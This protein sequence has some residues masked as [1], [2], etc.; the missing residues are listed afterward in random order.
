MSYRPRYKLVNEGGKKDEENKQRRRRGA[1]L[2]PCCFFFLLALLA[3]IAIVVV[4]LIA[5]YVVHPSTLVITPVTTTTTTTLAPTTTTTAILTTPPFQLSCGLTDYYGELEETSVASNVTITGMGCNG[6]NVTITEQTSNTFNK[7]EPEVHHYYHE[8][9]N[10]VMDFNLMVL[11]P[12]SITH[13]IQPILSNQTKKKR[14][15]KRDIG[16]FPMAKMVENV[17]FIGQGEGST[18]Q[19]TRE[20]Y[21]PTDN[22]NFFLMTIPMF[23]INR[24]LTIDL[25]TDMV[26][27]WD[28]NTL[29]TPPCI[30]TMIT[31][32]YP[33]TLRFDHELGKY[34]VGLLNGDI[35]C[36]AISNTNDPGGSWG[37]LTFQN[38]TFSTYSG[39]L[40]FGIWS[41]TYNFCWLENNMG[42]QHCIMMQRNETTPK[43]AIVM[44]NLFPIDN[45]ATINVPAVH[46]LHQGLSS[47][48][49]FGPCGTFAVANDQRQQLQLMICNTIN[50]DTQM[51]TFTSSYMNTSWVSGWDFPCNSV[52]NGGCIVTGDFPS[53]PIQTFSNR[54]RMAYYN[55]GTFE[56]LAYVWQTDLGVSRTKLLWGEF[57]TPQLYTQL[58][59]TPNILDGGGEIYYF[60]PSIVY[61]CRESLYVTFTQ[62]SN[63]TSIFQDFTYR[64]KTDSPNQLRTGPLLQ[65]D[66]SSYEDGP[67]LTPNWVMPYAFPN[68]LVPRTARFSTYNTKTEV[69]IQ[70]R[71][72]NQII[73]RNFTG[74]DG[75][76]NTVSCTQNIYLGTIANCST[77]FQCDSV[78]GSAPTF[79][80][81]APP[82]APM[83]AQVMYYNN[84]IYYASGNRGIILSGQYLW[85]INENTLALGDNLYP[86]D[87]P[88][89]DQI[90]GMGYW[91]NG[92]RFI[93]SERNYQNLWSTNVTGGDVQ[94]LMVLDR[95]RRGIAIKGD[96]AYLSSAASSGSPFVYSVQEIALNNNTVLRNVSAYDTAGF[97]RVAFGMATHPITGQIWMVWA[98]RDLP[99]SGSLRWIGIY[100]PQTGFCTRVCKGPVLTDV[101]GIAFDSH[102]RLWLVQGGDPPGGIYMFERGTPCLC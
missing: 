97:I 42:K 70:V 13:G 19:Q 92:N 86:M 39:A 73:Q 43:I 47:R 72:Q 33:V 102:G 81:N 7:R 8:K 38:A 49:T 91:Q 56:K 62:T 4:V 32:Y 14:R 17:F 28:L 52:L 36:V 88:W 2:T 35:F 85:P 69:L 18:V 63:T 89:E 96:L 57:Y 78:G 99:F 22:D 46:P 1:L 16:T 26:S 3:S 75:C 23:Q 76:N 87:Y 93:F 84:A 59:I 54:L 15:H 74:T 51:A 50:F 80:M 45:T 55:Y 44:D 29:F 58:P 11:S 10:V 77:A 20:V 34:V 30:D 37:L 66:Y 68:T 21:T 40:E 101:S 5:V 67:S 48:S 9:R 98:S 82:L 25:G 24:Y 61:D 41:N 12:T 71:L 27:S 79:L 100:D 64:L 6:T 31:N 94:L 60:A 90:I 65:V 83:G 53:N 95:E